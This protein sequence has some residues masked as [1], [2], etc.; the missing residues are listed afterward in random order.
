MADFLNN[1]LLRSTA[2]Q[3]QAAFL[4][5]RLPSLFEP[6]HGPSKTPMP[7]PDPLVQEPITPTAELST[8]EVPQSQLRS[9]LSTISVEHRPFAILNDG[10]QSNLFQEDALPTKQ[11]TRLSISQQI[12]F[13][14]PVTPVE[15][16]KE[17]ILPDDA[18]EATVSTPSLIKENPPQA[19]VE[20]NKTLRTESL[21]VP[22]QTDEEMDLPK[23][24]AKN[25]LETRI[26]PVK[27]DFFVKNVV[28]PNRE[29]LPLKAKSNQ[30]TILQPILPASRT[31]RRQQFEMSNQEEQQRVV[32][33]HI[34]RIEVRATPA[35]VN[36]Q[37]KPR[38][39]SIMTLDEYLQR[40]NAGDR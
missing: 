2:D 38:S 39:T 27:E 37:A 9:K 15:E 14:K 19:L 36:Q 34:G 1:L 12:Q 29:P 20:R 18:H 22:V 40:R 3:P 10:N 4:Q 11:E 25:S 28:S 26:R 24:I 33:I 21:S 31:T 6:L 8:T 35:P 5:P 7:S 30:A 16:L 17:A 13:A 23:K 32:E